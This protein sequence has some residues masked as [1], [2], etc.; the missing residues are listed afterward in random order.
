MK[1]LILLTQISVFIIISVFTFIA[2]LRTQKALS[3]LF[4]LFYVIAIYFLSYLIGVW[5]DSQMAKGINIYFDHDGMINGLVTIML[6]RLALLNV[7]IVLYKRF[8][9]QQLN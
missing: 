6:W 8:T 7:I 3:I 2:I 4:I 5:Q 9:S 1:W